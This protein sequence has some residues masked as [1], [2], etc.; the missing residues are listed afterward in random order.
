MIYEVKVQYKKID[1]DGMEK[2]FKDAYAV[3]DFELFAEVEGYMQNFFDIDNIHDFDVTDIKR[4]RIK[5]VANARED[6]NDKVFMAEVKD[7][8]HKDDGTEK[9][10]KYKILFFATDF[11][12]AKVFICEYIKQGYSMALIV[13]KETKFMDILHY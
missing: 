6:E 8:F 3:E 5:E 11:D 1:D 13:L 9:D 10:L 4:S 12:A 7:V 2:L